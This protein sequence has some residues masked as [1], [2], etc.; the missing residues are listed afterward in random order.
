MKV[1]YFYSRVDSEMEAIGKTRTWSRT[2]AARY[3][4]D[5]KQLPLKTFLSLYG[6]SK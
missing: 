4:A 2:A 5:T 3:F 6:V 1:Y